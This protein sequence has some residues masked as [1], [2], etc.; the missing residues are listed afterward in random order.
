MSADLFRYVFVAVAF[1]FLF[2][3]EPDVWDR[4][5]DKAMSMEVCK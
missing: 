5:H 2:E 4:L 1:I 3:G